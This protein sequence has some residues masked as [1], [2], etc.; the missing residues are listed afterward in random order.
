MLP[1]HSRQFTKALAYANGPSFL[2]KTN[3]FFTPSY[4]KSSKYVAQLA[5]ANEAKNAIHKDASSTHSSNPP[6][7]STSSSN[8]NLPRMAPSHRGMTYDIIE[9]NPPGDDETLSP[10]PSR[11]N[12]SDKYSGLDVLGDGLEVRYMGAA[13]KPDHEAAAVRANHPMPAQ[14]GIYYYEVKMLAKSTEGY[15]VF[16]AF[17]TLVLHH[18]KLL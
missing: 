14:C 5:A 17:S 18:T 15:V 16:L 6:S 8:V 11:W 1:E 13:N 2:N 4:L 10:L 9:H 7:L 12:E 3:P